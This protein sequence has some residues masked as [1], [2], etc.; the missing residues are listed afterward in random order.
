MKDKIAESAAA[1]LMKSRPFAYSDVFCHPPLAQGAAFD[2]YGTIK[3]DIAPEIACV[4]KNESNCTVFLPDGTW[5][6]TWSQGS[7]EHAMDECLVCAVSSDM[8]R[9]WSKPRPVLK[10]TP[11]ERL[12]YG[13]PFVVPSTGRIYVFQF[14]GWQLGGSFKTPEYD[15]GNLFF[16]YSDDNGESWSERRKIELPDK[17]I[18]IYLGRFHG[19]V[20]HPPQIMPSGDVILPLSM[21]PNFLPRRG[22]AWMAL[23]A[24]VSVVKCENILSESDPSKLRFSLLPEGPRGI[25]ADVRRNWDNPSLKRLLEQFDTEPYEA[26]YN[27]QE[28]TTVP[29]SDGR[30][31]GV[32][33]TFLGSPGFTVSEDNGRTWSPVEQLRYSPDGEPVKHPMT[34][35]PIAKTSD[36]RVVLLFTNNDGS[37]RGARHVWDGNGRTRNPQW[38]C[39]GREIPG[40]RR[41]GGMLFGKPMILAEVDDSGEANL[42]TGVSMPQFFERDGR[43][44]VMYNINKEHILLDEIPSSTLDSLT[45]AL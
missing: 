7:F 10:S 21:F 23:P 42:K 43:F 34:M 4:C 31:L 28:M 17:D 5:F 8:G 1:K 24:E 18:S 36:G 37:M 12:A 13:A 32:G 16:V 3:K 20:N 39:V 25:R 38:I 11:E 30:W 9:T 14:A 33:R 2:L 29:L 26:A 40:E 19:W 6:T 45:P 27:F 22:R 44:F 15:C 35:C 41:N